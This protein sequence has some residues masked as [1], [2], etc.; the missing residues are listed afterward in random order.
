MADN[1]NFFTFFS[2][3]QNKLINNFNIIVQELNKHGINIEKNALL[4]K[5]GVCDGLSKLF[6]FYCHQ[7]RSDEFDFFISFINRL[8]AIEIKDLINQY[9]NNRN[10]VIGIKNSNLCYPFYKLLD[11]MAAVQKAHS[12]QTATH[13]KSIFANWDATHVIACS[14]KED[15]AKALKEFNLLKSN[16]GNVKEFKFISTLYHTMA[17]YIT[18]KKI[19]FYD[20]NSKNGI[21]ICK[22]EEDL[23]NALTRYMSKTDLAIGLVFYD[24]SY[25]DKR[26]GIDDLLE[27]HKDVLDILPNIKNLILHYQKGYLSRRDLVSILFE[28]IASFPSNDQDKITKFKNKINQYLITYPT[29]IILSTDVINKRLNT[30]EESLLSIACQI[31]NLELIKKLLSQDE[32]FTNYVDKN[33]KTA[34]MLASNEG[35][36]EV[37]RMLLDA[38]AD[39]NINVKGFSAL[40]M[41]A[42]K[43]DN[44]VI[45]VLLAKGA[46]IDIEDELGETPLI[47]SAVIGHIQ[48]VRTLLEN[49]A[50]INHVNKRGLSPLHYAVISGHN[51]IVHLLLS[52]GAKVD[53]LD[54]KEHTPLLKA[55]Y[56]GQAEAIQILLENG[57]DINRVSKKGMTPLTRAVQRGHIEVVKLLLK[58][59]ADV[60]SS[61]KSGI[62]ALEI[63]KIHGRDDIVTLL[64]EYI[65]THSI[66]KTNNK[67]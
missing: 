15:L 28:H 57:A 6:V 37:V 41:A 66:L 52:K 59:N 62:T 19:I 7:D 4:N 17:L 25:G 32:R 36:A 65:R 60:Y 44:E 5:E 12:T 2:K 29:K 48:V 47:F 18:D 31:S 22:N 11:F 14:S 33:G 1:R 54:K 38:G 63:A 50:D 61:N 21:T 67:L 53:I 35:H 16:K 58:N 55:A 34:I 27:N 42:G 43:G 23:A 9:K 3:D 45:K 40:L 51:D 13:F 24:V 26:R 10:L 49:G 46:K 30:H 39:P 64:E 56:Y 20:P 8:S